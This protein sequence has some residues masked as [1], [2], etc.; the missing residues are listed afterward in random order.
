[1]SVNVK[2]GN[3]VWAI[4]KCNPLYFQLISLMHMASLLRTLNGRNH[5]TVNYDKQYKNN[6]KMS[7]KPKWI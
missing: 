5:K 4:I 3:S 6:K 2:I 1:M 7:P